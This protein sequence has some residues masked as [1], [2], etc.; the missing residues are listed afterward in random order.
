MRSPRLEPFATILIRGIKGGHVT[1]AWASVLAY[2]TGRA[3]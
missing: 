1:L 2:E 3:G